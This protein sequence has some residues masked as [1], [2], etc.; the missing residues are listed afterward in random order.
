MLVVMRERWSIE[1]GCLTPTLKIKRGGIEAL[2][3]P[4]VDAWYAEPAEVL[5]T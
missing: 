3:A 5:W 4:R 1:N 2:L